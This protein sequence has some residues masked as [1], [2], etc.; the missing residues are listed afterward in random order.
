VTGGYPALIIRRS[1]PGIH[2]QVG[3]TLMFRKLTLPCGLIC[4]LAL[5]LPAVFSGGEYNSGIKWD[6]PKVVEPGTQ[7]S[8][9]SDA[10][11]LFDGKDLSQWNGGDKWIIKDGYAISAKQGITTKEKFGDCQLHVEWA[12]PAK[13]KGSGQGRGN[14]G[15]YM[16]ER[17]EIQVL[18]SYNNPT[19]F[20]GQ[21]AAVYKQQPPM[22][23][24]CRKPGEWQTYDILFTVPLFDD[25]KKL[26]KPAYA[27]VLQNG[28]VVQN[29]TKIIGATSHDQP[30]AYK[31]H[32]PKEPIHLQFHGDPVHFRNIWV[33]EMKEIYGKKPE[34]KEG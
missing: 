2:I 9:P 13:V 26:K 10:L 32:A 19:Y 21:A 25:N 15:V 4:T 6:E 24:A 17:Y 8:P 27:T 7:G 3:D 1:C 29:H 28:I 20:D 5:S 30:P 31:A 34:G 18:D 12:S 16:M 14:S 23:N 22:V 33:R 11:V